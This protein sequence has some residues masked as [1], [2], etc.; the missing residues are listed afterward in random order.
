MI[1]L[2]NITKEY[3]TTKYTSKSILNIFFNKVV[4]VRSLNN[5]NLKINKGEV[6]G[7]LG[8]NGAGKTT[9][10]KLLCQ[11]IEPTSGEIFIG[12]LNANMAKSKIGLMLGNMMIYHRLTGYDNLRYFAEIYSVGDYESRIKEL[13]SFLNMEDFIYELVETYS[14]GMKTKLA[15]A[16]ALISNP[17]ILTLDEPTTG[18][19]PNVSASLRKKVLELKKEG[20]TIILATHS[21]EE[22]DFLCDRIA[23]L[24][25]GELIMVGSPNE[26]KKILHK[27]SANLS[28]VFIKLSKNKL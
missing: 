15:L 18:L 22:A 5:I 8:P 16:R 21:M 3:L 25:K 14:E 28:E 4:K 27:K 9:L 2:K 7:I 10:I 17:D 23:F 13:I 24:N 11:L 20:K 6:F 26:L 19:D 1:E 12:G